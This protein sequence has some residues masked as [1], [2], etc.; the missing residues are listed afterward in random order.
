MATSLQLAVEPQPSAPLEA[1]RSW[2]RDLI[3]AGHFTGRIWSWVCV[4]E[5]YFLKIPRMG[6]GQPEADLIDG[7]AEAEREYGLTQRLAKSLQ[8][9]I[10][11]PLR[12]VDGCLVKRRLTGPDLWALAKE[13]G[14]TPRVQTAITHGVVLAAQLHRLDPAA[15]PGLAI[16]DYANDRYL[17]AP[18]ALRDRLGQRRRTIVLGGL[19][20]R[21][22]KQDHDDGRW[23]F[24]DPHNAVLGA[25]EEDFARYIQS[26]LM[27]NWGRHANCRIW[28]R[29]RFQQLVEVYETTRGAA[30]DLD[31]LAYM[32]ERNVARVRSD[33]R[34]FGDW[35]RF[36]RRVA[37][38]A[39]EE[40][41]LWQIRKWGSHHG[42]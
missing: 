36:L 17:P 12:L 24:F 39:Y 29:F 27:I 41:F 11:T 21:N 13:E 9:M 20:V 15:V 5:R 33:V 4:T 42:L 19:E 34:A 28:T 18:A 10:D 26:L 22:F 30:L 25:P 6:S 14:A 7:A 1:W 37:A 40:L 32:F 3:C 16:H 31:L 38:R 2:V 8:G 23:L 35:S